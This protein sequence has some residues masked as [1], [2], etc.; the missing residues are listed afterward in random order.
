M[1]NEVEETRSEVN[2]SKTTNRE[3]AAIAVME[4]DCNYQCHK[5][6]KRYWPLLFLIKG[7][8]CGDCC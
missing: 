3:E 4:R 8:C 2:R 7:T 5:I 1:R 6:R